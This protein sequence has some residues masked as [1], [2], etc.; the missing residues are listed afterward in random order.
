MNEKCS[1]KSGGGGGGAAGGGGAGGV[2]LDYIKGSS[3]QKDTLYIIIS[4][5][6]LIN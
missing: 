2:C 1:S 3:S 4:H 5:H 6:L